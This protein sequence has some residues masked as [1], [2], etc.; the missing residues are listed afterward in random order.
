MPT[1]R[2]L[3]LVHVTMLPMKPD[4][5]LSGYV[6][7]VGVRLAEAGHAVEVL[8]YVTPGAREPPAVAGLSWRLAV[9]PRRC[10]WRVTA[11]ARGHLERAIPGADV[12]H[13]QGMRTG[14]NAV[15][16][17]LARRHGV[18]LVVSPHG[19]VH[20]WLRSQRR[21][22]KRVVDALWDAR[23]YRQA[24]VAVAMT[25]DEADHVRAFAPRLKTA[26]V[27]IGVEPPA[28]PD[29]AVWQRL[30]LE[31][32]HLD[33]SRRKVFFLANFN[34]RKGFDLLIEAFAG[35]AGRES[36]QLVMAG[37]PGETRPEG[38]RAILRAA[39]LGEGDAVLLPRLNAEERTALLGNVDTFAMPSRSENFGI[40]VLEALAAGV[41]VFATDATPWA[42]IDPTGE[43]VRTDPPTVKG[44][45][46][47]LE[48]LLAE[49]PARRAERVTRGRVMLEERFRWGPVIK[50]LVGVYRDVATENGT[51]RR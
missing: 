33:T 15:A 26:V 1:D 28:A 41:P 44:I 21:W 23:A 36:L 43:V 9:A 7:D 40:V 10:A 18:P 37:A 32:P 11:E 38:V 12:V 24:A 22:R 49:E 14:L 6:R 4:G 35:L 39:A 34:R 5:G 31:H 29:P 8:G 42:R 46:R 25:E 27:P 2:P 47:G 30:S 50:A 13:L 16:A 48:V 51:K 17:S 20:P 19:Q 45:R 3:R